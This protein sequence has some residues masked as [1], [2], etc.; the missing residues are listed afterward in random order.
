VLEYAALAEFFADA[1]I[2]TPFSYDTLPDETPHRAVAISI[3]GGLGLTL[4]QAF[5]R[6]TFQILT[7]GV[8]GSDAFD[9]AMEIDDA[10]L[11]AEPGFDLGGYRVIDKGRFGGPPAYVATDDRKRVLRAATYYME[12]ER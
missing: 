7:R 1:G 8:N 4:E 2:S 12:I 3:T 11:D 5:D 10:L 9:L 6:P